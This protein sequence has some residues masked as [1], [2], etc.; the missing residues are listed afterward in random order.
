MKKIIILS[1]VIIVLIGLTIYAQNNKSD[2]PYNKQLLEW[3][4]LAEAGDTAAM[5]R[6]IEFYDEH[7]SAYIE[8]VEAIDPEGDE[9][10]M[11]SI[12][13]SDE[14]EIA[15]PTDELYN[16][17]LEYWLEKGLSMGDPVALYTKGMRAYY[18]DEKNAIDYLSK[19]ADNGNPQAALFCGSACF[20]QGKGEE[21]FKY[22][23]LAYKL[24]V[25]SAGWHLAICYSDGIGT[26]PNREK[27]IEVM[28]HAALMDYPEA[29]SEMHRIE[30]GNMVW[31]HK[32]DS[33]GIEF[34]DFPIIKNYGYQRN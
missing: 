16:Q 30:P 29:I 1:I 26:P 6:L 14:E 27:A 28:R 12:P 34:V 2:S 18:K 13:V 21:A 9:I 10:P 11:D 4:R 22:L 5:H 20:N 31:Q 24:G 25:P 33:L 3:E 8:I 19:A 17:R 23:S 15:D 7:S 32:A